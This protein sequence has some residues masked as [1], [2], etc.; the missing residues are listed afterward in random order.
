MEQEEGRELEIDREHPWV[1]FNLDSASFFFHCREAFG[2][3]TKRKVYAI[4]R[5][6]ASKYASPSDEKHEEYF[7]GALCAICC[8]A[9]MESA[10]E[11]KP[12]GSY[13]FRSDKLFPDPKDGSESK[14][15][16]DFLNSGTLSEALDRFW[17]R[18]AQI[19]SNTS[20]RGQRNKETTDKRRTCSVHDI[21][22]HS[23]DSEY[24]H[25]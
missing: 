24:D 10:D 11:K 17:V 6:A 25:D 15:R 19:G 8:R 16:R 2:G 7:Q 21:E 3:M 18:C 22:N 4:A 1:R 5:K 23:G 13:F 9:L 14:R 20:T 12:S